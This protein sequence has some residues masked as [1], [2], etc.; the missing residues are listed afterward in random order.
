MRAFAFQRTVA[1]R[2]GD[3]CRFDRLRAG[4]VGDR[5]GDAR[6]AVERACGEMTAR[7]CAPQERRGAR[8][9]HA[10]LAHVACGDRGVDL[11]AR[12]AVALA[13]HGAR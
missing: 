7:G 4:E 5:S 6:D 3:V 13:L 10:I 9:E 8:T 12:P 11:A 1:D 2:F